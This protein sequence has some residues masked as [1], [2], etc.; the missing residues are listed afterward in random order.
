MQ[1]VPRRKALWLEVGAFVAWIVFAD[2][3]NVGSYSYWEH[4]FNPFR[5]WPNIT[6]G[7]ASLGTLLVVAFVMWSSGDRWKA[8]GIRRFQWKTD[9]LLTIF[10]TALLV[11]LY[12]L[13]VRFSPNSDIVRSRELY[14]APE[15]LLV[16]ISVAFSIAMAVLFEEVFFRGY[17][18]SRIEELSGNVWVGVVVAAG[19]FGFGHLYQ[20]LLGG[21]LALGMGLAFGIAFVGRRSIWP[22]AIAHFCC[23]LTIAYL[24]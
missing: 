11:S 19:I 1:E 7:L 21:V 9:V 12:Y 18:I 10:L 22:L 5:P 16:G 20:G 15:T 23:N 17:L 4:W 2:L 24:I 3:N 6:S 13:P 8:F 14:P